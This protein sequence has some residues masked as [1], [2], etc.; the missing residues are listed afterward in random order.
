MIAG[1]L[2]LGAPGGTAIFSDDTASDVRDEWRDAIVDGL[3]AEDATRRLLDSID[4]YL[5][6]PTPLV[7][8][9]RS[10]QACPSDP[11]L[12]VLLDAPD[13]GSGGSN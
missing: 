6:E 8:L 12:G 3:G 1:H 13:P 10:A 11:G 4:G 9:R 7:R 5:A 2:A